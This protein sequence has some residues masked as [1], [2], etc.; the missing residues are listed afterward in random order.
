MNAER[1]TGAIADLQ[2]DSPFSG[3]ALVEA[4]GETVYAQAF[5]YANKADGILNAVD[6]RFQTASGC[7]IFTAVAICQLVERGAIQFNTPLRDCLDV[8]FPAYDPQITIAHL[9]THTAGVP[10]YFDE[11]F[12]DDY[13]AL[14]ID[15]PMYTIR[16]PKDF[17]PMFQNEPM[18][19]PCGE[20]FSYNNAGFIIL[21][22]IVE[23]QAQ[24]DFTTYVQQHIFDAAG[25][26]DS[27]YFALDQLPARTANAYIRQDDGSWKTNIYAVPIIGGPDGG[28]FTTAPDM[29]R[30]W[31]ALVNHQLLT[32][33]TTRQMLTAH[34]AATSEGDNIAYGY[35]VWMTQFADEWAY[36]VEGGDPGVRLMSRHFPE[37]DVVITTIGNTDYGMGKVYDLIEA[38]VLH[39]A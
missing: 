3:V 7:K 14:W 11:E 16:S 31:K 33:A 32:E 12:M 22:L 4:R 26:S 24:M 23:Q 6:T 37:R 36:H 15:R 34:V 9:L 21:G 2:Q 13:A 18:K 17:L 25:M 28:A 39:S 5:G 35:G 20:R 8:D 1:L 30:F 29:S 19:F 10:D 38:E 27:G